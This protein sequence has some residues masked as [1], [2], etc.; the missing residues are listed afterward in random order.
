[1][2]LQ[3]AR[4]LHLLLLL[5][6]LPGTMLSPG[7]RGASFSSSNLSSNSSS[8]S[9]RN[10]MRNKGS[11]RTGNRTGNGSRSS[12]SCSSSSCP[13]LTL[14]RRFLSCNSSNNNNNISSR[15]P[16]HSPLSRPSRQCSL[17]GLSNRLSRR[18][19]HVTWVPAQPC[20][21]RRRQQG[22]RHPRNSHPPGHIEPNSARCPLCVLCALA[23]QPTVDH[24][25][26]PLPTQKP[27]AI[28]DH[29]A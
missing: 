29:G 7:R 27:H 3:Q 23:S 14:E 6:L 10:K 12:S 26:S 8:S 22:W 4:R 13:L 11:N 9:S 28:A 19:L 24:R 21:C 1:M 20:R 25:P 2:Q 17:N 5:L 18:L 16:H 15:L